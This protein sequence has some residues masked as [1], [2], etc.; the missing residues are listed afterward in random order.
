PPCRRGSRLR[1]ARACGVRRQ[2]GGRPGPGAGPGPGLTVAEMPLLARSSPERLDLDVPEPA[3]R[4]VVLQA[5]VA[6]PGMVLVGDVEFVLRTV[7][8]AI[9]TRPLVEVHPGDR[10]AVE[11]DSDPGAVAGDDHVIPLAGRL[12]GVARRLDQVV[13]RPGV[14]VAGGGGVV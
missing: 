7:G 12:H 6:G 3:G 8:A 2:A 9:G 1:H 11:L 14:V 10:L 4:A 5:D 13:D